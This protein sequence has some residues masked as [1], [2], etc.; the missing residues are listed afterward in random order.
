MA[1]NA[2]K[3]GVSVA[4]RV[5]AVL[6]AFDAE[7]RSLTLSELAKRRSTP[8]VIM[9]GHHPL[10]T[11]GVHKDNPILIKDWDI[12]LRQHKVD[13]YITGHDHDLQHLEF[14][15]HPT[16]FVISGGGGAEL[17]DWTI[18]P[19]KRGPFGGKVLGFTDMEMIKDAVILRHFDQNARELH[20]FR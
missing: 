8:F 10:Y 17:V 1:G 7:H 4:S 5:L 11:N 19:E 12:L 9:V 2:S 16:S 15:G 13:F 18:P 14:A 3:P 20:S 6:G